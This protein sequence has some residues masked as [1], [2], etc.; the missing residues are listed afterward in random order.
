[1]TTSRSF[2]LRIQPQVRDA[3]S[4]GSLHYLTKKDAYTSTAVSKRDTPADQKDLFSD[5]PATSDV[6]LYQAEDTGLFRAW[7]YESPEARDLLFG[8]GVNGEF[9]E[10]VV[11]VR[12]DI[13][14]DS[15]WCESHQVCA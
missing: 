5:Y 14:Q 9:H 7:W 4:L 2:V 6:D 13:F 11:P 10:H 8:G 3:F 1:M 12:D 15:H